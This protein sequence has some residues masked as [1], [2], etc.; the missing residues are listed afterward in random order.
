VYQKAYV[1][2]FVSPELFGK[3]LPAFARHPHLTY[4]AMDSNGTCVCGRHSLVV[5]NSRQLFVRFCGATGREY[6]NLTTETATAVTW[7]VFP[8]REIIQPTIVDPVSFRV[9]KDEAF[10]LWLR[11]VR[12]WGNDVS[13]ATGL[14]HTRAWVVVSGPP[15]AVVVY[16]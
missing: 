15:V 4:H 3:L 11:P 8:R 2:F 10:Q 12:V 16:G 14:C 7:G 13:C 6:R 1:E 5:L 9:W